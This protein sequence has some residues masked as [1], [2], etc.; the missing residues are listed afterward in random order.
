M[1]RCGVAWCGVV[2][3][4][5]AWCGVVWC[6]V[7]VLCCV[8]LCCVASVVGFVRGLALF[9]RKFAGLDVFVGRLVGLVVFVGRFVGLVVYVA[10]YVGGL[11]NPAM[12][13][14]QLVLPP[15]RRARCPAKEMLPGTRMGFT[16]ADTHTVFNHIIVTLTLDCFRGG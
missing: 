14:L 6:G 5:V 13:H 3:C 1:V 15:H 9:V 2:W 8:V 4:G 7:V 12:A 11:E 16:A 10:R